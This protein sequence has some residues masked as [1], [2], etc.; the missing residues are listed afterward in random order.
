MSQGRAS[1]RYCVEVSAPTGQSSIT[2]P[3]NGARYGSL[4]K[5]VISV[6]AP[7]VPRDELVVL[8]DVGREPRAAVTEDAALAVER[9]QRRDGD[10]L[11]E[12]DLRERHPRVAG[13][14]AEGQVLQRALAA[15]VA[16][17]AVERMVDEDELER[18][19]LALGRL[20]RCGRGLDDH[21][22]LRGEP[23]A[24]LELRQP[25]D[26]DEAHPAGADRRAEPGLVTED[27]DLDPGGGGGLD[28]PGAL[29]HLDLAVVDLDLDELG[30]AAPARE[31][32][33]GRAWRRVQGAGRATR[34]RG[35]GSRP[36]R[37]APGTR[38]G[39]CRSSSS[40]RSRRSRRAGRGTCR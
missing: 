25:L 39:T 22:V 16:D 31:R 40:P 9:D 12:R 23:A 30:H 28:E 5:V 32:G 14:V 27:G 24:G 35:T 18:R 13:A 37:C 38:R 34:R 26:L 4:S 6:W 21:P 11:L 20:L 10:R 33:R 8:G 36:R 17:G 19:V 3:E 1:K 7:A 29:R 15:L 2:L